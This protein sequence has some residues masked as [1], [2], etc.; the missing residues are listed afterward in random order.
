M[1]NKKFSKAFGILIG[2]YVEG[3]ISVNQLATDIMEISVTHP[4]G[5][6]SMS[7]YTADKVIEIM[8]ALNSLDL[9]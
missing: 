1:N 5:N 2:Q 7:Q 6:D 4:L 9:T 3:L 8:S